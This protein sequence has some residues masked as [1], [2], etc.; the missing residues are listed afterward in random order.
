MCSVR[1]Q[2]ERAIWRY[3]PED[4]TL[5]SYRCGPQIEHRLRVFEK[6]LFEI[7]FVGGAK[8]G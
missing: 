3:V 2:I 7:L 4:S 1:R 8:S 6:Q 5:R